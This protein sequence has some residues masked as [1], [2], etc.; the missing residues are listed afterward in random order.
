[1]PSKSLLRTIILRAFV[2]NG[3]YLVQDSP[4]VLMSQGGGHRRRAH[5]LIIS[6]HS[7]LIAALQASNNVRVQG[8]ALRTSS[9]W[10]YY[11]NTHSLPRTRLRLPYAPTW[12]PPRPRP[13]ELFGNL[14]SLRCGRRSDLPPLSASLTRE[15]KAP[16]RAPGNRSTLRTAPGAEPGRV[17]RG[18]L[19]PGAPRTLCVSDPNLASPPPPP[20][21]PPACL[22]HCLLLLLQPG[23]AASSSLVLPPGGQKDQTG[24][25]RTLGRF[26][27]ASF[28]ISIFWSSACL[29]FSSKKTIMSTLGSMSL[30]EISLAWL[31]VGRLGLSV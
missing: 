31:T 25:L 6:S 16:D 26:F 9:S 17:Q 18:V 21:P 12:C 28:C 7:T 8:L 13:W 30:A 14:Y 4:A 5:P 19:Q 20:P 1:M 15:R 24:S 3:S 10:V 29:H 11:G 2:G 22:A 23:R 27:S